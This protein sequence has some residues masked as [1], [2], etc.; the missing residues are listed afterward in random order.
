M[1]HR[2]FS[3]SALPR[4]LFPSLLLGASLAACVGHPL[5]ASLTGSSPSPTPDVFACAREQ[6]KALG[7]DQS[8]VDVKEYRLQAKRYDETVRR[9][10]VNFRRLVDRL[11]IEIAPGAGGAV[12]SIEVTART[13]AELTT[14]RGPTEEQERTSETARQAAQTLLD[15]CGAP[16]APPA[17]Q[18]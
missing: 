5:A 8:S 7:F 17:G 18:G 15:R 14:Q 2:A 12:T 11:E 10:D 13:F 3:S 6:V 9:P 1:S 16:V 4:R